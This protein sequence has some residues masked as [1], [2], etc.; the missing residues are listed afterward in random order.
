[1]NK[2]IL[3]IV[4]VLVSGTV[5][6]YDKCKVVEVTEIKKDT[7]VDTEEIK[8]K[9]VVLFCKKTKLIADEDVKVKLIK[10]IEGC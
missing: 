2:I 7:E 8:G 6:A 1:M 3:C 9:K 4:L 10:K 5:L